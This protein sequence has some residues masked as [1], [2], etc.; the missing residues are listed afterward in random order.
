MGAD[1]E[2]PRVGRYAVW[3]YDQYPYFIC[4]KIEA[5][6]PRDRSKRLKAGEPKWAVYAEGYGNYLW[7]PLITLPPKLGKQVKELRDELDQRNRTEK[8]L[9]AQTSNKILIEAL[10]GRGEAARIVDHVLP[11]RIRP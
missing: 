4:A 11:E 5:V 3:R 9:V 8:E 7:V 1:L 2:R 10:E 6:K